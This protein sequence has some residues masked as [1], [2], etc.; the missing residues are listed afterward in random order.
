MLWLGT[1]KRAGLMENAASMEIPGKRGFPQML[2][3]IPQKP[4]GFSHIFHMPLFEYFSLS[5]FV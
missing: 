1:G 4:A 2:G 3:K 5:V